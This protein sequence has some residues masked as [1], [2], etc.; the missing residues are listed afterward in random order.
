MDQKS[1]YYS[2]I[3]LN[4]LVLSLTEQPETEKVAIT[5]DGHPEVLDESGKTLSEPVSRPVD[6]NK[7]GF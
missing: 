7:V 5:V 1:R 3:L 4:S 6:V 2:R